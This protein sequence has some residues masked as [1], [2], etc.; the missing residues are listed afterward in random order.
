LVEKETE[1]L[2]N[3]RALLEKLSEYVKKG[4]VE[5]TRNAAEEVVRCGIDPLTAIEEG[6][7]P[8]VRDVGAMFGKGEVFLPDLIM[9]AEA[10][11]AGLEILK[12]KI[13]KGKERTTNGR[14][15]I[16]TVKGDIHYI[17]K[18]IVASMLEANGFEVYDIREDVDVEKFIQKVREVDADILGM[19]SLM[20]TTMPEMEKV[21]GALVKTGLRETIKVIVGGAPIT[22]D[23]VQRLGADALGG[24]AQMA[25]E[26]VRE[27]MKELRKKRQG[28]K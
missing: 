2:L 8:G 21:M 22:E 3:D 28:M 24:D 17:G 20:T 26:R 13:P 11:K 1:L 5:A 12:P 27:L 10:M 6:M 18:S 14:I 15:V 19:S 16:G 7:G 23:F 4:D 25:V 9:S